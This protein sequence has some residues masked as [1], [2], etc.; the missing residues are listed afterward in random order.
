ME[1]HQ[2]RRPATKVQLD[3]LSK[4]R[5]GMDVQAMADLTTTEVQGLLNEQYRAVQARFPEGS[6]VVLHRR[7]PKNVT[8]QRYLRDAK[9]GVLK[10]LL[11]LSNG[12]WT[13]CNLVN[14]LNATMVTASMETCDFRWA[15][16]RQKV[17]DAAHDFLRRVPNTLDLDRA[18]EAATTIIVRKEIAHGKPLSRM[19]PPELTDDQI[20]AL[21]KEHIE[22]AYNLFE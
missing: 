19:D 17:R 4:F 9:T 21:V 14:L 22:T 16:V 13:E 10:V 3:L 6:T 7:Q 12:K 11:R 8:I 18:V 1:K 5:P 20:Q 2:E 15:A